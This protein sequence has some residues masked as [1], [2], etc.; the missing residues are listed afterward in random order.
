MRHKV[1]A[2]KPQI[3]KPR[4]KISVSTQVAKANDIIDQG[5]CFQD[6]VNV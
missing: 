6:R 4:P 3:P 1:D 5:F 2:V